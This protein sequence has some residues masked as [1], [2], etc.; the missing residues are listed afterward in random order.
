MADARLEWGNPTRELPIRSVWATANTLDPNLHQSIFHFIR[1]QSLLRK[2]FELEAVVA[3]DSA[4]QALKTLLVTGGIADS[5]TPRPEL[6]AFP[7]LGLG[8]DE[9]APQGTFLRNH[10]GAHAGARRGVDDRML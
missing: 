8:A 4:L 3:L 2:E 6:C 7:G 9:I 10:L 1:G 5:G